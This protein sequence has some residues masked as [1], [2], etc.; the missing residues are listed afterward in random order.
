M[1]PNQDDDRLA[2]PESAATFEA[3]SFRH[4]SEPVCWLRRVISGVANLAKRVHVGVALSTS[5]SKLSGHVGPK[6][7][8]EWFGAF[9]DVYTFR[10]PPP[11]QSSPG[12]KGSSPGPQCPSWK[13]SCAK[14]SPW[15]SPRSRPSECVSPNISQYG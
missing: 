6:R 3:G 11:H 14:L 15:V 5:S 10:V 13:G 2:P 7:G 1:T 12:R 4:I 8:F 9:N